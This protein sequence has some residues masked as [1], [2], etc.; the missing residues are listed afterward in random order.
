M[1][2]PDS[3]WSKIPGANPL[4]SRS[5]IITLAVLVA[6]VVFMWMV[7]KGGYMDAGTCAAGLLLLREIGAS[8]LGHQLRADKATNGK[9]PN[10]TP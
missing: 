7:L 10:P 1:S 6:F 5:T 4:R 9:P 3:H 2:N 8:A